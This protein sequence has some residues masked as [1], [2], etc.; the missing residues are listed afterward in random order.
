MRIFNSV[1]IRC[2]SFRFWDAESD[3]GAPMIDMSQSS[4][5]WEKKLSKYMRGGRFNCY[6]RK[7]IKR[8]L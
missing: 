7:S 6:Y 4:L 1:L 5:V 2:R 8:W 3:D